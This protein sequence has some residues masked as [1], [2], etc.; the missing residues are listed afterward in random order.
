MPP[1]VVRRQQHRVHEVQEQHGEPGESPATRFCG[2]CLLGSQVSFSSPR[3]GAEM[4][5]TRLLGATQKTGNKKHIAKQ[6]VSPPPPPTKTTKIR[7]SDKNKSRTNNCLGTPP[8]RGLHFSALVLLPLRL[9]GTRCLG[10]IR[11][12]PSVL[13]GNRNSPPVEHPL[14]PRLQDSKHRNSRSK[15]NGKLSLPPPVPAVGSGMCQNTLEVGMD[16]HGPLNQ[17]SRSIP[18]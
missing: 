9:T 6:G 18:R 3:F 14:A 2:F 11:I 13:D 5:R 17:Y 12:N 7:T 1:E 4:H 15:K 16:G 10:P 8:N